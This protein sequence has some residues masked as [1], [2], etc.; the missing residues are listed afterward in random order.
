MIALLKQSMETLL[1]SQWLII[2]WSKY[3]CLASQ[4][5]FVSFDTC[6]SNSD[7]TS[8]CVAS[9]SLSSADTCENISTPT[10]SLEGLE[11]SIYANVISGDSI[12]IKRNK[13]IQIY[14]QNPSKSLETGFPFDSKIIQFT[15]LI[16]ELLD[17]SLKMYDSKDKEDSV[18]VL[19]VGNTEARASS[20]L[21][22]VVVPNEAY[23]NIKPWWVSFFSMRFVEGRVYEVT[24][25]LVPV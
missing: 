20:A 18:L 22:L 15:N 16:E 19:N 2:S 9:V 8:V 10:I 6:Q 1:F 23:L 24:I 5:N 13:N 14:T 11:A 3:Y 4:S 12:P 17:F 21:K 7:I 25:K